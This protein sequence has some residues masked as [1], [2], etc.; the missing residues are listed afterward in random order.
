MYPASQAFLLKVSH[1]DLPR[2]LVTLIRSNRVWYVVWMKQERIFHKNSDVLQIICSS[3]NFQ[4]I[5]CLFVLCTPVKKSGF[6]L[7]LTGGSIAQGIMLLTYCS[8]WQEKDWHS[9]FEK[10]WSISI[11]VKYHSQA[12]YYCVTMSW[13]THHSA[14]TICFWTS[15][16]TVLSQVLHLF[17]C[18]S[19]TLVH[20]FL[21]FNEYC[22]R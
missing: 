4:F 3:V 6:I 18:L 22:V 15:K 14:L 10:Q 11:T 1:L 2:P 7:L 12:C 16:V 13:L 5:I 19:F 21:S 9:P 20:F 8:C 17:L